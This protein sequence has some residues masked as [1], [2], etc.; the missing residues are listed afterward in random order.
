[1]IEAGV[2]YAGQSE[3]FQTQMMEQLRDDVDTIYAGPDNSG[4]PL[5]MPPGLTAKPMGYTSV[6]AQ[7]IEQRLV[8]REEVGGVFQIPPG[9]LG[10]LRVGDVA[11]A[12]QR[13]M[14]YMDALAPPL[15]LI[16][17]L[18]NAQ[19]VRTLLRD[20][21]RSVEFDLSGLLRG[22][23]LKETEALREQIASAMLTPNEARSINNMPQSDVPAMD[24]FFLPFNNLWPVDQEPPKSGAKNLQQADT[25]PAP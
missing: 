20:K 6:E 25:S 1:V 13:Q 18:I 21:E 4:R 16:E 24:K 7:L 2:E 23:K 19:V 15:L 22:D 9:V 10:F 12:E 11:L 3:A 14:A 8:A 17:A 5:L